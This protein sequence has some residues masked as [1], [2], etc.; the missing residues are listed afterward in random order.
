MNLDGYRKINCN[1]YYISTYILI[2]SY[3]LLKPITFLVDTGCEITTI[4]YSDALDFR[5]DNITGESMKGKAV[6]GVVDNVPL[7]NCA[8]YCVTT[9]LQSYWEALNIVLVSKP[10]I[11][12]ENWD[13]IKSVPSL[14][15]MDFL[16]H[17]KISF[18]NNRVVLEK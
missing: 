7:Y 2:P 16:Q 12:W 11:T 18:P 14:L 10:D 13:A 4:S 8:L 1:A 15:G 3:S 6:G 9:N 5:I 17:Y